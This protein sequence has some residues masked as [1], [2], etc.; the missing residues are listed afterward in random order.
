VSFLHEA[1]EFYLFDT[2]VLDTHLDGE[3]EA[4]ALACPLRVKNGHLDRR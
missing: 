1:L 4:A 2:P 3:S